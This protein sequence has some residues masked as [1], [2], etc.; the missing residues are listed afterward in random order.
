VSQHLKGLEEAL[1][2]DQELNRRA[3]ALE[4]QLRP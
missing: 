4:Q 3:Q 1:L 2:K